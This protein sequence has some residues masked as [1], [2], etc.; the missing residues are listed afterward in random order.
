MITSPVRFSFVV[1]ACRQD[2]PLLKYCA[3]SIRNLMKT[4]GGC[5]VIV[6]DTDNPLDA[7]L[8][9]PQH[10]LMLKSGSR[11]NR[12]DGLDN[13]INELTI[14][15]KVGALT[16]CDW[17]IKVDCD[18]IINN[19][20]W[21]LN[22]DA[23]VGGVFHRIYS[24][25]FHPCGLCYAI[26]P[27]C[28]EQIRKLLEEPTIR[29]AIDD[30]FRNGEDRVISSLVPLT[31]FRLL[32]VNACVCGSHTLTMTQYFPES[33]RALNDFLDFGAVTFKK[34]GL[35]YDTVEDAR[36][37]MQQYVEL[38]DETNGTGVS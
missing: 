20:N 6:D 13:V 25:I 28:A 11:K 4:V 27:S 33:G 24:N 29:H 30:G 18:T 1:F 5:L 16:R 34:A 9:I 7:S 38:K 35:D 3:N 12:L 23:T 19:L 26:R 15:S 2:Q 14:F 8:G 17:V 21:M 32:D 22:A 36:K 37:L 31:T 10:E